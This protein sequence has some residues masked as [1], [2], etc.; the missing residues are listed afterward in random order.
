MIT[1]GPVFGE[2]RRQATAGTK[3]AYD[4]ASNDTAN[5]GNFLTGNRITAFGGCSYVTDN[6]GNVTSRTCSGQTVTFTWTAESRLASSSVGGQTIA[7]QYDAA[8]WLVR[9]DVNGAPQS[10]FVW[11]GDNLLAELTSTGTGLVA[12][13]S[14]FGPDQ[15][16]ALFVGGTEYNA[17]ADG[18]GDVIALTDGAQTVKRT[19]GYTAWGQSAGGSDLRPFTNADR[20]RFKGALWLGPEVELYYMR[21]R[22]YEPQSGR[23]LSE[24]P[25]GLAGGVN[26]YLYSGDDPVNGGDPSGQC[27]YLTATQGDQV[28]W[29]GWVDCEG[30]GGGDFP[31]RGPNPGGLGA[32]S[33]IGGGNGGQQ[34]KPNKPGPRPPRRESLKQCVGRNLSTG[35]A[36]IGGALALGAVGG[37]TAL[38]TGLNQVSTGAALATSARAGYAIFSS[39]QVAT[40]GASGYIAAPLGAQVAAQTAAYASAATAGEGLV[41]GGASLVSLGLGTIAVS[42]AFVAGY[43]VGTLIGCGLGII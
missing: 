10:H 18:L 12:E 37:G 24:D 17:H 41:A 19:Y 25:I 31:P 16:H 42:A 1:R 34:P 21:A 43:G 13:Y 29:A 33:L 4:A 35:A 28:L 8:G 38:A 20:A 36:V 6:D 3:F 22:W 11:D 32:I 7:F 9:K 15:L 30:G 40:V 2:H 14:Y 26:P 27:Y 5:G 39:V 23:F